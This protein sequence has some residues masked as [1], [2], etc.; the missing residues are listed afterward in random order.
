MAMLH[1]FPVL[2]WGGA[3]LLG[4]IAAEL[5][6]GEQL[7][8]P[9]VAEI[10]QR[11]GVSLRAFELVGAPRS[12]R[13]SSSPSALCSC[14]HAGRRGKPRL[15]HR[16]ECSAA[17]R[18]P[19]KVEAWRAPIKPPISAPGTDDRP[20][21]VT[22]PAPP[23]NR[24]AF[25]GTR[26]VTVKSD[27]EIAR[28]ATMKPIAE[29]AAKVGIPADALVPY[30]TTK[31]KVS[32]DY[33]NSL[34][35]RQGRQ[36]HPRHRHQPDAGRRRQ[37]DDDGRPRRRPQPHRQEGD[38]VPAR[39]LARALL[40]RQGRRGRRRLCPGRADGGHQPPLHRRLPR[41]H[42][43]A[44]PALGDDRQPHLLG[45]RARHRQPPRRLAARA[46]H[47]R[48]RAALDR[49]LARRRLE[50]LPARGR[51][52]HHGRL[53][54]DGHLLPVARSEGSR[55]PPRQHHRRLHARQDAGPRARAQGRRRHDGAARRT[56]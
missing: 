50:R 38:D 26:P 39:A 15:T 41:H 20:A 52:R 19:E 22:P 3:A 10:T 53:R 2:V 29:V 5:I 11:L 55:A 37:D 48:P 56:R 47:E 7:L 12:A 23:K 27:I 25:G 17:S 13:C 33:I 44:Q 35:D 1:K 24:S 6:V 32:F 18:L 42:V 43:G 31:A 49:Q 45:Q 9:L 36:A 34:K 4:W 16:G 40:R 21:R 51:L 54:G 8:Q 28:A 46:R 14:G 30:G